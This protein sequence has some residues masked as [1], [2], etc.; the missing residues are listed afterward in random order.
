MTGHTT[1]IY[2]RS[3]WSWGWLFSRYVRYSSYSLF[4]IVNF[5]FWKRTYLAEV[6]T[7][8]LVS[9]LE[10]SNVTGNENHKFPIPPAIIQYFDGPVHL[11]KHERTSHLRSWEEEKACSSLLSES[12]ILF[13]EGLISPQYTFQSRLMK[14]PR[15][16]AQK[17][18]KT[19]IYHKV[20]AL[21]SYFQS[22]IW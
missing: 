11:P 5:H 8:S 6:I 16:Q 21:I 2:P 15:K 13:V 10:V 9:Q 14:R 18:R 1:S 3:F 17:K 19:G 12:P 22:S 20:M 7:Y 4:Y